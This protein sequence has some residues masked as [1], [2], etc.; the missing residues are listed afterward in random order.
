MATN[1]HRSGD[2]LLSR[3]GGA[4][5]FRS[6][7]NAGRKAVPPKLPESLDLD[8]VEVCVFLLKD[9]FGG[10]ED[11]DEGIEGCCGHFD[12]QTLFPRPGV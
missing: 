6:A 11:A 10:G 8:F 5:F 9:R 1:R 2:G 3:N 12:F 4:M 7:F